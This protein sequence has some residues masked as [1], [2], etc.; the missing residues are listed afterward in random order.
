MGRKSSWTGKRLYLPI[1]GGLIC[2][3][4]FGC[5]TVEKTTVQV[6]VS[7][8]PGKAKE[9]KDT[10]TASLGLGEQEKMSV[11]PQRDANE[12]SHAKDTK[13]HEHLLLGQKLFMQRDYE[14]SL[15]EYKK[16]LSLSEN[17]PPADEALF[18]IGLIYAHPK[19]PRRDLAMALSVF[20]Q[21]IKNHP[22]SPGAEQGKIWIALF[23]E[24]E[25][26]KQLIEKSK[27]VDLD[28]EEMKKERAK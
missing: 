21:L 11:P 6:E 3:S 10:S 8:T 16:A 25:T 2:L 9:A 7:N 26:L 18:N 12:Q 1:A 23:E 5:T 17:S 19:N 24:N 27:Q 4:L 20:Q 14:G 28:V 13:I 15:K 22:Q